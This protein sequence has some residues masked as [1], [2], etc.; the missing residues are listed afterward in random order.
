[1]PTIRY[2]L[3][4]AIGLVLLLGA[5]F[6][7]NRLQAFPTLISEEAVQDGAK[8]TVRFQ[9][10]PRDNPTTTYSDTEQFIQ[11]QHSIP[12]G[13]EQRMAGMHPGEITTFPLSAEEG[14][15][16]HDE[17]K[18]QIIPT[19]DLPLEAREG[20]TLTDDA[21]RRARII[22]ILPEKALIDLNHPLAGQPLIVT[23]EIV[24]IE[25]PDEEVNTNT[26]P[27]HDNHPKLIVAPAGFPRGTGKGEWSDGVHGKILCGVQTEVLAER[28]VT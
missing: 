1:M 20:D 7:V 5:G 21:G 18:L 13:L 24:M 22:W 26:V 19:G 10:T 4:S 11:G 25:N 17:T 12:P 16:P 14:F 9:I 15:G 8:V 23:L 28:S 6:F 27:G 3:I 2:L